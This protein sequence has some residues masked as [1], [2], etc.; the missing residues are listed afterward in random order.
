MIL[1][2]GF[3][4]RLRPLTDT[5]PKPLLPVGGTP[6]IVWN[7]CLLRY[8]GFKDVI[9]NVHYLGHLIAKELGDGTRWGVRITYSREPIILGTGGGIKEAE[10]F[11][12][13]EPFLVLNGDTLVDLNLTELIER[14]DERIGMATMVI[15]ED[16]HVEKWGVIETTEDDRVVSIN[17]QGWPQGKRKI[18]LLRRMFAGI[19]VM[20]PRLL[21]HCPPGRPSSI[22]DAYVAELSQGTSV[23]GYR[24][25]GYWSDVGTPECYMQARRDVEAGR[26]S[27][28][29]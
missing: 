28:K 11:F 19:H 12:D 13:G 29:K 8:H 16:P 1:A 21:R 7:L 26:I 22:I 9:I 25:S 27:L 4:T 10:W 24:T 3:G 20:H 2:A 18:S 17:G 14:H 15:R 5:I 23:Y 6:L